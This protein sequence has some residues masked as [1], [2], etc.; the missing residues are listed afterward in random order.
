MIDHLSQAFLTNQPAT[1]NPFEAV[2][3]LRVMDA[4]ALSAREG[5]PVAVARD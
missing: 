5:K 4:L 3:S 1:P 2:K